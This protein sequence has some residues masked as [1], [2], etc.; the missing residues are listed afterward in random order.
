MIYPKFI[1][2]KALIGVTAPSNGITKKE[3]LYRLD[4]AIKKLREQGFNIKETSNVR[5]SIK[6]KS[7]ASKT[8]AKELLEL[9]QDKDVT[10]IICASGGD[11][12]LE[13]LPYIDFNI[14]KKILNGYKVI[15]IQPA[16]FI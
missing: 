3:E 7:S 13:I 5:T 14:I 12:L 15:Q 1:K 16:C 11:F 2:E 9:F 4:S 6:G 10:S 8:Q